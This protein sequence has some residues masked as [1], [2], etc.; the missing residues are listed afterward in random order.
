[1]K[2]GIRF[3]F[4]AHVAALAFGLGGI[5]IALPNPHLWADSEWGAE[6]FRFGM[7]YGGV[8]HIVFG[9]LTMLL[10]GGYY[11]GWRRTLTFFV[12]T[13]AISLSSELIGT[14]TGWPFGNYEYTT[15]LGYKILG[16]VPFTIPLSWFYVGFSSYLLAATLVKGRRWRFASLLAVLGGAYLL[17]VWDLVL[18]P[19][20]AHEDLVI[21]FWTWSEGGPYFGM[22]LI[23]FTGW[24]LTAAMFM[25]ISRL[26][27][28]TDPDPTDYPSTMPFLIY[29]ANIIF[30]SALSLSVDLW[31]PV[32]IAAVFGV[33]PAAV[34]WRSEPPAV[35]RAS[36]DTDTDYRATNTELRETPA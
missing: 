12:V 28:R 25:G 3:S 29:L 22:P 8:L 10:F 17:T 27:W 7:E 19:A 16:Q 20:M 34:A 6:V 26:L 33:I 35:T 2:N 13:V 31:E 21:Q 11:L 4:I 15:G 23:N 18:D 5:L 9:A 30:A 36:R 1:M 24:A 32:L 14:G